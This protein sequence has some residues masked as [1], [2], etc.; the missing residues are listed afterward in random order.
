MKK[1]IVTSVQPNG[2]W[3]GQYG[4]MYKFEVKM[5][6]GDVGEYLSKYKEQAKFIVGQE[7][8]Y[9]YTSGNYPKI[10]PIST[11]NN[12]APKTNVRSEKTEE[13]IVKQNAL[14]NA[15][16]VIG[17]ADVVRILEVAEVFSNWVL[18]VEKPNETKKD[19]PF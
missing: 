2:T 9:N 6:N 3:E 15:C 19:L 11:F 8:E 13:L 4:L 7:V 16:N 5:E 17:E 1:A 18:N 10:K 14:T 12:S